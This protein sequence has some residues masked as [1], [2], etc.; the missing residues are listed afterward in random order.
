MVNFKL[1]EICRTQFE[2][3][4]LQEVFHQN[5]RE[6]IEQILKGEYPFVA[7]NFGKTSLN[8]DLGSGLLVASKFN[9][10]KSEFVAFGNGVGS[11]KDI[12][13]GVLAVK[14]DVSSLR[15]NTS[16]YVVNTSLQRSPDGSSGWQGLQ[17]KEELAQKTR[18]QQL[19]VVKGLIDKLAEEEKVKLKNTA[20]VLCGS[21]SVVAEEIIVDT[22]QMWMQSHLL[23]SLVERLSDAEFNG[24]SSW[25]LF[26]VFLRFR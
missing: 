25:S 19:A 20:F 7:S 16:L 3:I 12:D 4:C 18:E 9:I 14:L 21:F 5:S 15:E 13:R 6:L 23:P 8:T 2:I 22:K 10:E 1:K 11:D 24:T 17:N 26:L